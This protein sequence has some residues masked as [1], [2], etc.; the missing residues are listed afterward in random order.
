MI[1]LFL[2]VLFFVGASIQVL[3]T[4]SHFTFN[5]ILIKGILS[6]FYVTNGISF[7]VYAGLSHLFPIPYSVAELLADLETMIEKELKRAI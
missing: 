2:L 5:N 1:I 7:I 6:I 4:K 3:K